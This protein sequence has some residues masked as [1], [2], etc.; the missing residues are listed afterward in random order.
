LVHNTSGLER[1]VEFFAATSDPWVRLHLQCAPPALGAGS[2]RRV[3]DYF[4]G[5][6]RVAASSLQ[7]VCDWLR[8]CECL[9]DEALFFQEDFWPHFHTHVQGGYPRFQAG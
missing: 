1:R 2:T 7:E 8:G 9:S 4:Q 5:I 3:S 6:S